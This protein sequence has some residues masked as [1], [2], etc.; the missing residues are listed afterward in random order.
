MFADTR[1]A[2]QEGARRLDRYVGQLEQVSITG[3]EDGGG[4]LREAQ[5]VVVIPVAR[6]DPD[7]L[8]IGDQHCVRANVGDEV[9]AGRGGDAPFDP[10]IRQHAGELCQQPV[11]NDELEL[12]APPALDQIRG[13][14]SGCEDRGDE[15]VGIEDGPQLP[16]S[17]ATF[18]CQ[19]APSP[20]LSLEREL[21]GVVFVHCSQFAVL[22]PKTFPHVVAAIPP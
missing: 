9:G 4:A 7:R 2:L 17:F 12:S 20:P 1:K 13:S 6:P 21:H 19:L 18:G 11:R 16:R 8:T 3:D 14:M 10:W 15:D 22:V 5:E